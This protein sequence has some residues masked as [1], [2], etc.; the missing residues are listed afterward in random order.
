MRGVTIW[1]EPLPLAV[2]KAPDCAD[3]PNMTTLRTTDQAATFFTEPTCGSIWRT[4]SMRG[5]AVSPDLIFQS[6]V[7]GTPDKSA[8]RWSCLLSNGS[9]HV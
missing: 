3:I 6:V 2:E 5:F 4:V 9:S 1:V 8:S 7:N